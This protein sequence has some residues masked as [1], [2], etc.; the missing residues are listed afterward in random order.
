[1]DRFH[2]S[3]KLMPHTYLVSMKIVYLDSIQAR[4]YI[5]SK[6]SY[7]K[8]KRDIVFLIFIY[9]IEFCVVG[10]MTGKN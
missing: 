4:L 5:I 9:K 10:H 6:M 3:K 7:L 2:I 1:M 8:T